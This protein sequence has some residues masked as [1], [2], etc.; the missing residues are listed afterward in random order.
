M[1]KSLNF[2]MQTILQF[3]E[4]LTFAV[5]FGGMAEW[6]NA[7]VLKTGIRESVSGVRIPIP[8][9]YKSRD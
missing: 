4:Y 8:P 5:H 3:R 7:P 9:H 6:L 2:L 1:K